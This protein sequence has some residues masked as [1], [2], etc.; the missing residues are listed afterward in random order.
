MFE[1]VLVPVWYISYSKMIAKEAYLAS[2]LSPSTPVF[3]HI[4]SIIG[5]MVLKKATKPIKNELLQV[6]ES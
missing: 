4:R 2:Y 3:M 6:I 1:L 5:S